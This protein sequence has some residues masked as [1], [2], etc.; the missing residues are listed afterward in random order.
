MKPSQ[1]ENVLNLALEARKQNRNFIPLFTGDAGIGKSEIGQ[2]WAKKQGDD[3]GLIDLRIAYLESPDINGFPFVLKDKDGQEITVFALPEF[4]PKTGSGLLM[5]EEPNRGNQSVMNCLMQILTDRKIGKYTLPDGWIIAGFINPDNKFYTVNSMDTALYNR[6]EEF[7][8]RYDHQEFLKFAENTK[9]HPN[10]LNFLKANNW[11][12]S[13]P[14]DIGNK[15]KY[16]SPRTWSKVSAME[17]AM[18]VVGRDDSLHTAGTN[19]ILGEIVGNMYSK[20]IFEITPVSATDLINDKVK[21]IEKLKK[22]SDVNTFRGDLLGVT[23]DSMV[24]E[25]DKLGMDLVMEI[26]TILPATLC[27]DL[28]EKLIEVDKFE[29]LKELITKYPSVKEHLVTNLRK[30]AESADNEEKVG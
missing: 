27:S 7:V 20:F 19:G 12:Y 25:V 28:L 6:F 26:A 11:V 22:Y 8:V 23:I 29:D 24:S 17:Y 16:I 18:D 5:L 3:F 4:L 2:G 13:S 9:Y 10:V 15:G 1:I 21:A 30:S 14:E